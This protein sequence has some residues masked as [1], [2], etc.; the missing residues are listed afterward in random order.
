M[1]DTWVRSLGWKAPLEE[2]M[3]AHSSIHAWRMPWT[4]DPGKLQ[5]IGSQRAGH[6]WATELNKSEADVF[7]EL[8][9]FFDDPMDIGNLI[10]GSSAF[11][12]S[13]FNIWNFM[14]HVLLKNGLE[15]FEYYFDSM[16]NEFNCATVWA[17]FGIALVWDENE[18]WSFPI[19][20]PLLSFLNFLVN[21]VQH[22]HSIFF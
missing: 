13:S 5:S 18:N 3:A 16:W 22:F 19:L 8:S 1:Q 21:L 4:E 12:K 9:C 15:N 7:L 20:W 17:F 2:G 11:S 6:G 14:V 10:S